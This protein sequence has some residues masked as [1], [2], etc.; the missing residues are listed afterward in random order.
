M[1][2]KRH[3]LTTVGEALLRL[4]VPKGERLERMRSLDVTVGGAESNVA[5]AVAHM[6]F[7][8][9]WV[10]RLPSSPLGRLVERTIY[11]HGVDTSGVV[12]TD[13]GRIGTY[14]IEFAAAPRRIEVVYDR[15]ARLSPS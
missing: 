2:E 13:Q 1:A 10:S 7:R 9:A 12:W 5:S 8:A 6:G 11:A 14:F 4:S 15:R 3:D